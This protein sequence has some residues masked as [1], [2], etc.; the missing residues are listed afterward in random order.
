VKASAWSG[1]AVVIEE[2]ELGG[3][4]R[5]MGPFSP[6]DRRLERAFE[7]ISERFDRAG[8]PTG[9][10]RM[11]VSSSALRRFARLG[12]RESFGR[13]RHVPRRSSSSEGV[14]IEV[15]QP[16][17]IEVLLSDLAQAGLEDAPRAP[18]H[19]T[20]LG[21]RVPFNYTRGT[22][23]EWSIRFLA[24][25]LTTE[26]SSKNVYVV[27]AGQPAPRPVAGLSF[28]TPPPAP[29]W[30][31]IERDV[32]YV[33]PAPESADPWAWSMFFTDF[34]DWPYWEPEEGRF[35]LP[36]LPSGLAGEIPIEAHFYGYSRH[37]HEIEARINGY[38]IGRVTF[39]GATAAVIFGRVPAGVL[40]ASDNSLSF[41]YSATPLPGVPPDEWAIAC[42][43]R[44][45]LGVSLSPGTG[46][47]AEISAYSAQLPRLR[48][49]EY[50]IVTH[51]LF[52]EQAGRLAAAKEAQGLRTAVVDVENAYDAFTAGFADPNAVQALIRR[53]ALQSRRLK[54]IVLL[55]DDTV[56]PHDNMEMGS[57][58]YIP[59]QHA[60][61]KDSGRV[62]SETP[63]T[64][65]N[66]DGRPDVAIG[67]LPLQTPEEADAVVDKILNQTATLAELHGRHL[68]VA[69]NAGDDDLPF[70]SEADAIA[71]RLPAGSLVAWSDVASGAGA[72]RAALDAAW[73]AGT[74][75]VHFFGHGG[76]DVWT[77][78][79]LLSVETIGERLAA[80]PPAIVLTWTCQA[81]W[82]VYPWGP[83]VN[84]QLLLQPSAG[85]LAAFGPAG[86]TPPAGQKQLYDKL[87]DV[88]FAPNDM[89]L[90]EVILRSKRRALAEAPGSRSA[91]DT[92]CLFGDP[93]L[94][95]P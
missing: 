69:D 37:T 75:T 89:T 71:S 50:L 70:R 67:R 29:G 43:D 85:A 61:H 86:A 11:A 4:R 68:F 76:P 91:V 81:Q 92:F 42:L 9:N 20:H 52:A 82:Y 38:S 10:V 16:G 84:E 21:R 6:H 65:L 60:W 58:A 51:R 45:D 18:L 24:A 1:G 5:A 88:M 63:Y 23:G 22:A 7:R 90:G 53:A 94:R 72:A 79:Q 54:Y 8:L 40:L 25:P 59:S 27:T 47:V 34:G 32:A 74:S 41:S 14:K 77:D 35:D 78:E 39:E 15:A 93:A 2:I 66:G 31:R 12:S 64:D 44:V 48:G 33:A 55:G 26:Y 19:L 49:V 56:D 83:T 13:P 80:A 28:V 36:G 3:R 46:T 73:N 95:L 57:M 30:T 62:P 17:W 87:Y